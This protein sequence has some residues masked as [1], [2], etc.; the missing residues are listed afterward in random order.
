MVE[1]AKKKIGRPKTGR[2]D[3]YVCLPLNLS[4]KQ[5]LVEYA[6]QLKTP[7]TTLMRTLI[8]QNLPPIQQESK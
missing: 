1:I 7:V 3:N 2:R 6:K 4:E 5:I 8:F